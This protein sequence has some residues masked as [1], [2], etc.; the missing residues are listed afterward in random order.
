[1]KTRAYVRGERIAVI[2]V[3]SNS[4]RVVVL[5]RDTSAHL[6]AVAGARASLRLIRDVDERGAFS[7]ATMARTMAALRDF[8]A[9]AAGAGAKQVVAVATAAVRDAANGALLTQRV[10]RELGIGIDIISGAAEARYGF[11]GAV[12]GLDVSDGVLFDLGGG[13]LE[14][15]RF[16]DRRRGDDVSLSLGALRVSERFLESDP[17]TRSQIRRLREHVRNQLAKAGVKRLG[18]RHQLVGT[19]GTLRNLAKIDHRARRYPIGSLHGYELPVDRLN[20]TVEF[21]AATKEKHRD[22]LQGLSA[23]R[24][25]SIVGGAVVIQ[26]L[27][28]FVG[29][30]HIVVSGQGLREGLGLKVLGIPMG[31]RERV[32]EAALS[33]LV[34]R[35]DGWNREAA[36]R[37]Q[38]IAASLYRALEPGGSSMAAT[39]VDQAARVL[40]IGR[41]LDV[42]DRHKHV[43]DILLNTEMNGFTH[44]E[45]ALLSAIVRRAGDRNADIPR[46][47]VGGDV[48]AAAVDR[49]AIVLALADEIEA[50]CPR[51]IPITIR[52]RIDRHVTLS[53]PALASWLVRDLDNRF[54]RAFGRTLVVRH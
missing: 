12:R 16:R 46:L 1:M 50:R 52:T 15:T 13:S 22:R 8:K 49:A 14:L 43:A 53:V 39:A 17:P 7:D 45:L 6:R 31:A 20:E 42:I 47:A 36:S 28:D 11:T 34:A 24:A 10:R 29:A 26:T 4:S 41:S 23:G 27:A 2:D 54:A 38:T 3:G 37:R 19:G 18:R 33:S 35:F 32:R 40:D 48:D 21:L 5:E 25:D 30:T 44:G 9:L 51:R